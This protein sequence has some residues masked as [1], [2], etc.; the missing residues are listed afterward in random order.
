M[1]ASTDYFLR[2]EVTRKAK[3]FLNSVGVPVSV[4]GAVQSA[5]K[6]QLDYL[7]QLDIAEIDLGETNAEGVSP[8]LAAIQEKDAAVIDYLLIRQDVVEKIDQR[9]MAFQHN[10]MSFALANKDYAVA[11]RLHSFGADASVE[12]EPGLPFLISAVKNRDSEMVD[13]LLDHGVDVNDQGTYPAS[14]LA[15]AADHDDLKLMDRIIDAGG[16]P[17][18]KG[19]S[20]EPLLIESALLGQYDE[21]GLLIEKG[22]DIAIES[23]GK[24]L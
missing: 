10:P 21:V 19:R 22:A 9:P 17:D 23:M 18:G 14:A 12:K 4:D 2:H 6:G 20:M 15:L 24:T 13:F 7:E 1:S 3:R 5:R 11:K 16:D 8:L